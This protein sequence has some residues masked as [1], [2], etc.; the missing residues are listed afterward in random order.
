MGGALGI[1]GFEFQDSECFDHK[2]QTLN[3][4]PFGEIS[5]PEYSAKLKHTLR[6]DISYE[7][8]AR[9]ETRI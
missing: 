5:L 7:A 3:L 4:K 1:E 9:L 6:R 8:E 2:P